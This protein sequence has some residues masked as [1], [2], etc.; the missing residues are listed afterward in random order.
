MKESLLFVFEIL[1]GAFLIGLGLLYLFSQ[2]KT[3]S[4]LT[5]VVAEDIIEDSGVYQQYNDIFAENIPHDYLYATI[6]GYKEYPIM[7]DENF[8]PQ[9]GQDYELYFSYIKKGYYKKIYVFGESRKIQLIMFVY[10]GT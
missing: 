7:V 9:N 1:I 5:E 10:I 2:Q 6:M 3:L 8:I 4:Q